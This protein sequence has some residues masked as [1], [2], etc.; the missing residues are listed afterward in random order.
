[1]K[2][3]LLKCF[4]PTVYIKAGFIKYGEKQRNHV[5]H[6]LTINGNS[7]I[8]TLVCPLSDFGICSKILVFLLS[9]EFI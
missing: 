3:E 5:L 8:Q 6:Y 2:H 1:M 4:I 7:C 9:L